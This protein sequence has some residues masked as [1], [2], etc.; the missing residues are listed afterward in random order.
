MHV[1]VLVVQRGK[2]GCEE[3]DKTQNDQLDIISREFEGPRLQEQTL[4]DIEH[5]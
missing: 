2:F 3:R 5:V 1:Q 4:N